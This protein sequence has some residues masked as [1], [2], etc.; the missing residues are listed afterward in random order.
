MKLRHT[1]KLLEYINSMPINTIFCLITFIGTN[2]LKLKTIQLESMLYSNNSKIDVLQ[3]IVFIQ[4]I[5]A[6]LY[7]ISNIIVH[8]LVSYSYQK[9]LRNTLCDYLKLKFTSFINIGVGAIQCL[10]FRRSSSFCDFLEGALV[11]IFPKLLF[12]ITILLNSILI[13]EKDAKMFFITFLTI[14]VSIITLLQVLRSFIYLKINFNYEMANSKRIEILE[15]YERIISYNI[16]DFE[17]EQY[18]DLLHKYSIFKQIFELLGSLIN[19]FS[20]LSL[21]IF[22]IYTWKWISDPE[23]ASQS[24]ILT[25]KLKDSV[26]LILLELD[27]LI[28]DHANYKYSRYKPVDKENDFEKVK[29]MD[30]KNNISINAFS[31]KYGDKSI[32]NNLNLLIKNN[33]KVA[34]TGFNGCGKSSLINAIVGFTNYNGSI[35]VDGVEIKNLSRS[36]ISKLIS[37]IPQNAKI[38]NKSI[39]D[40]LK[41]GRES[42]ENQDMIQVCNKLN[43]HEI[44][45]SLGYSK[46]AGN[47]GR[48][49]SGGQRQR[50]IL[51][52]AILKESQILIFDGPFTGLDQKTEED[53]ILY[54]KNEFKNKIFVCSTQNISL[55][56]H[57]DQIIF[58]DNGIAYKDTFEGLI[59]TNKAFRLFCR[60][61]K[62]NKL[63]LK[64]FTQILL[65]SIKKHIKTAIN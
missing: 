22:S 53:F 33:E 1:K 45:K 43:C 44:F 29:M 60:V 21:L 50:V 14:F 11:R 30:F 65:K 2:F 63:P 31:I 3:T 38:L 15:S 25:E 62:S 32:L 5:I 51:I 47:C 4:I 46:I 58:I 42:L 37:Y 57:F 64:L 28:I 36:T 10:I 24:I 20:G 16:L 41:I 48:L 35:K 55:L 56:P 27:V 9:I 7:F 54:L 19:L 52:S 49:L 17:L 26:Y 34:I 13:L 61:K 39:E 12:L 8:R 59:K 40:N 23:M 18:N 6:S